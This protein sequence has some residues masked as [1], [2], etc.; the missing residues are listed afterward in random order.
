VDPADYPLA[1]DP[2]AFAAQVAEIFPQGVCDY[3][4]PGE[5]VMPT[6][7][8]L[9]YGDSQQVIYGGEPLASDGQSAPRG[10]ASPAF[11]VEIR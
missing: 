1:L 4:K 6:Q 7:T 10:W 8:W 3:S 2:D 5:G 11:Q 9:Q